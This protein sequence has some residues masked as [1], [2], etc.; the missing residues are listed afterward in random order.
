MTHR[1]NEEEEEELNTEDPETPLLLLKDDLDTQARN[2]FINDR[3]ANKQYKFKDNSIATNKYYWWLFIPQ[4]LWY[5]FHRV[6]NL[7]FL[8]MSILQFI[9][10]LSPTGRYT[11]IFPLSAILT[12]TMIKELVEDIKRRE[13]DRKQNNRLTCRLQDG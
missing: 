9:P 3:E 11:T 2:L 8:L 6:A 12:I 10:G 5:Q 1:H 7:Y 13:A 4:N